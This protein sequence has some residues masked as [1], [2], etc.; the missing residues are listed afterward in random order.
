LLFGYTTIRKIFVEVLTLHLTPTEK[1]G[2]LTKKLT[3]ERKTMIIELSKE[4]LQNV[5]G[6]D[7]VTT[8][9]GWLGA[10]TAE[11]QEHSVALA[12]GG[13]VGVVIAH[14]ATKEK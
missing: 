4:S 9:G 3:N 10:G 7:V 5:S 1:P 8:I 11:L 13:L 2:H 14:Y 6:G 12:L